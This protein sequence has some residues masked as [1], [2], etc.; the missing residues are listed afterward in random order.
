MLD[1]QVLRRAGVAVFWTA[2]RDNGRGQSAEPAQRGDGVVRSP[3]GFFETIE[4][5]WAG[6]RHDVG[7]FF[8]LEVIGELLDFHGRKRRGRKTRDSKP[9]P[10]QS[11]P[12]R[13]SGPID[14]RR[15]R[16]RPRRQTIHTLSPSE[17]KRAASKKRRAEIHLNEIG[18]TAIRHISATRLAASR[19]RLLASARAF[20][21]LQI[22][23]RDFFQRSYSCRISSRG[24]FSRYAARRRKL[25]SFFTS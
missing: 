10:T 2:E 20:V 19:R 6:G 18:R 17:D 13:V 5:V 14:G 23:Q 24:H 21:W 25:Y 16:C 9:S 7:Q 11:E 1:R 15:G 8:D 12:T 4:R 3:A 22:G